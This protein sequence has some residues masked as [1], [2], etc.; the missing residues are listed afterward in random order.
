MRMRSLRT[1]VMGALTLLLA[2][3]PEMPPPTIPTD[4]P[5]RDVGTADAAMDASFDATGLDVPAMDAMADDVP[6]LDAPGADVPGL[7]APGLDAPG[8][9]APGLDAPRDAGP[10]EDI[11]LMLRDD[12]PCGSGD[13]CACAMHAP[14]CVAGACAASEE[15]ACI[16]DGCIETCVPRGA[17]CETPADCPAGGLCKFNGTTR[18]C[19]PVAPGCLDSRECPSGFACIAGACSDRRVGCD[20]DNLC[21][22]NFYCETSGPAYCLRLLRPCSADGGCPT[23]LCRDVDGDGDRECIAPGTCT[24]SAMCSGDDSCMT[25]PGEVFASC[26]RYGACATAADCASGQ[27]CLDLWGDGAR[28]CVDPGGTCTTTADCASGI[29]GTPGTG[30]PPTCLTR[31]LPL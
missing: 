19:S 11:T 6:G 7:D 29:C 16:D 20:P 13:A 9:D 25:R 22:H 4:V 28:E 1:G 21:P 10:P 15:L 5:R 2:A 18:N 17:P 8:L 27:L 14:A 3:C 31:S 12:G 23:G 26:G 24:S 30:G